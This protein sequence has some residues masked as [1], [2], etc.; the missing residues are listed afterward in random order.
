[1]TEFKL[2][3]CMYCWGFL[4]PGQKK[5]HLEHQNFFVAPGVFK[6][7]AAFIKLCQINGKLIQSPDMKDFKVALFNEQCLNVDHE[8]FGEPSGEE[9]INGIPR[10]SQKAAGMVAAVE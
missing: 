1:M 3:A 10:G 9:P 6:D 8:V 2:S 4:T 7:E 5:R